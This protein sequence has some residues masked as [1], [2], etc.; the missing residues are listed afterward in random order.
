M[1]V[2][3]AEILIEQNAAVLERIEELLAVAGN[4]QGYAIFGVTVILMIY[5]YKFLR[6]FF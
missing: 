5:S 6:M 2:E 3:Q 1:S 4:L